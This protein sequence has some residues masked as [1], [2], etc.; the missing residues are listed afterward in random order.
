LAGI[1]IPFE[2]M[3][4]RDGNTGTPLHASVNRLVNGRIALHTIVRYGGSTKVLSAILDKTFNVNMPTNTQLDNA[5]R[6]VDSWLD[7]HTRALMI[8][9]QYKDTWGKRRAN[10]LKVL[11]EHPDININA[12]DDRG[13]TALHY[14]INK[15]NSTWETAKNSIVEELLKYSNNFDLTLSDTR[16]LTPIALANQLN[17]PNVPRDILSLKEYATR[18]LHAALRLTITQ[19]ISALEKKVYGNDGINLVMTRMDERLILLEHAIFGTESEG[20]ILGRLGIL[21]QRLKCDEFDK[22]FKGGADPDMVVDGYNAFHVAIKE[23]MWNKERGKFLTIWNNIRNIEIQDENGM[24]ALHNLLVLKEPV[25]YVVKSIL[26]E[27]AMDLNIQDNEGN[28]V[29][30]YAVLTS[31]S[32][33]FLILDELLKKDYINTEIKKQGGSDSA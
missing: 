7:K 12:Q 32:M 30:H 14:A 17:K 10:V 9:A 21:E 29:L 15:K 31:P 23:N 25:F 13:L 20:G 4:R 28:T 3:S 1:N 11:V 33:P 27:S 16:K 26:A 2:L 19:R 18:K 22:A 24:T 6:T 5:N 8:A